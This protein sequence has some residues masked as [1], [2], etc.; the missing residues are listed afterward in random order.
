MQRRTESEL[1]KHRFEYWGKARESR[2]WNV[3]SA[4]D[5]SASILCVSRAICA[6][7]VCLSHQKSRNESWVH[8]TFCL[9]NATVHKTQKN[10]ARANRSVRKSPWS[11]LLPWMSLPE[12]WPRGT[13]PWC[14]HVILSSIKYVLFP[15]LI[16]KASTLRPSRL[17]QKLRKLS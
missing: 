15:V 16:F 12:T 7:R 1:G 6:A 4:C 17:R 9:L 13:F 8:L 11:S 14:C 3:V 5:H 10:S 2:R